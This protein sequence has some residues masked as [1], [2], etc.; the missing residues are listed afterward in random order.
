MGFLKQLLRTMRPSQS[1]VE[2]QD[3]HMLCLILEWRAETETL[4]RTRTAPREDPS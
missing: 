1:I 3:L 4:S 2:E